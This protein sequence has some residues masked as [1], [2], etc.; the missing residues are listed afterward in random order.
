MF[1]KISDFQ[2]V[3]QSESAATL[4]VFQQLSDKSLAQ[5]VSL[6]GRTLGRLANHIIETLSEMPHKLGLG[7]EEEKVDVQSAKELAVAY[8]NAAERLAVKINEHWTDASL[9]ATT[10]MYGEEWKNAFSLWVLITHQVHHRAQ[11]TVLMRQAGLNVPG[12][13]GPSKEEWEAMGLKALD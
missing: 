5:T 12:I 2:K 1:H 13:Y 10:N 4:K 3:W 11:M 9:D 7:I 6:G 8:Q